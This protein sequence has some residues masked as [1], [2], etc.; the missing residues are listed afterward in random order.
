[1]SKIKSILLL[2]FLW[3]AQISYANVI[4]G[5]AA[6]PDGYYDGV[7]GKKGADNILNALNTCISK[8]YNEIA[9]KG[10][11]PHYLKTDFYGDTLWDMYSTC[12]FDYEDA[13]KA[14]KQVCDGW[15]KEHAWFRTDGVGSI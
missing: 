7:S 9:Y 8:D 13:N 15:N 3:F 2:A 11:E 1:M 14:Q 6:I 12:H 5:V 10:L 4:T